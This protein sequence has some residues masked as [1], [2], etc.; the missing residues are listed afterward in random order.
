MKYHPHARYIWKAKLLSWRNTSVIIYDTIN[1]RPQ[2]EC[3]TS[4]DHTWSLIRAFPVCNA[5]FG[6]SKRKH[7]CLLPN[8]AD[9]GWSSS[10]RCRITKTGFSLGATLWTSE[11]HDLSRTQRKRLSNFRQSWWT[12]EIMVKLVFSANLI[13]KMQQCYEGILALFQSIVVMCSQANLFSMTL[14]CL[15]NLTQC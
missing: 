5:P 13:A 1:K 6:F 8:W 7:R 3:N 4:L 15:G 14:Y 2:V 10:S 12:W 9:A 11:L